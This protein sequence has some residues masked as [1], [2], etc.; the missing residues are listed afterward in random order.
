MIIKYYSVIAYRHHLT[1]VDIQRYK[2]LHWCRHFV[3][4]FQKVLVFKYKFYTIFWFLLT[5]FQ[6]IVSG[7]LLLSVFFLADQAS[8]TLLKL[9]STFDAFYLSRNASKR[10]NTWQVK[11]PVLSLHQVN[12]YLRIDPSN[13]AVLQKQRTL[14]LFFNF[15]FSLLLDAHKL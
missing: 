9:C 4:Y 2:Q 11:R 14:C 15:I 3:V 7:V 13:H 8:R 1:R 6:C 12:I 10:K 5:V